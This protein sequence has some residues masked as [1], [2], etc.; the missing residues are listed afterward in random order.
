MKRKKY[1][2]KNAKKKKF[3]VLATFDWGKSIF[4]FSLIIIIIYHKRSSQ[5]QRMLK[6]N[7]GTHQTKRVG[8][9]EDE[10]AFSG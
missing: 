9:V 5:H 4:F 3:F 6:T 8:C 7:G 10:D 2:V 1:K